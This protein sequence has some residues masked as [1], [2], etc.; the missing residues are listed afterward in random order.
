VIVVLPGAGAVVETRMSFMLLLLIGVPVVVV[1]VVVVI[2][3][4]RGKREQRGFP[5]EPPNSD[6]P[7]SP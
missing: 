6:V 3:L 2:A 5:V 1:F 7:P 4:T